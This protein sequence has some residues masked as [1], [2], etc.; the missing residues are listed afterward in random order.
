MKQTELDRLKA[1]FARYCGRF[2]TPRREDQLNYTLKEVHTRNVCRDIALIAGESGL[3]EDLVALAEAIGLFHDVGR[4]PQ[5]EQYG[6]FRDAVSVN[7]GLLGSKV[8]IQEGVLDGLPERERRIIITAVKYHN[9]FSIPD[10]GDNET[11]LFLRLI[12]D[13]DKLDIWRVFCEY[14]EG[15]EEDR[16]SAACLGFPDVPGYDGE[17]ISCLREGRVASLAHV[18]TLTDYK[19]MQLSWMFDIQFGTSYRLLNERNYIGR[20]AA[21][22]PTDGEIVTAVGKV[23]EYVQKRAG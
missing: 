12:R 2:H 1:W 21:V 11:V 20:Y 22:L 14:F 9:S 18:R 4:F 17:V 3:S 23:K 15:N 8:I 6:T 13:A 16:A 10:L 19:L 7:H 5:Y